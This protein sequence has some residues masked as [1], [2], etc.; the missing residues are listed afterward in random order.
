MKKFVLF[1]I[2]DQEFT[3]YSEKEWNVLIAE[4]R[5]QSEDDGIEGMLD[6]DEVVSYMGGDEYF[7][8][9]IE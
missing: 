5:K 1:D 3:F 7:W 4:W 6:V 2:A 9:E 8:S